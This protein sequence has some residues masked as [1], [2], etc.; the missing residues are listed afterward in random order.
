ME[1]LLGETALF[2]HRVEKDLGPAV[3]EAVEH[4]RQAGE[5]IAR[6]EGADRRRRRAQH[7][8]P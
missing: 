1:R 3:K 8:S 5:G 4:A 2:L 6:E 7:L